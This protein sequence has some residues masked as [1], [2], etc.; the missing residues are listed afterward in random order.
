MKRP[1][2]RTQRM[3]APKPA[4]VDTLRSYM[5]ATSENHNEEWSAELM[6]QAPYWEYLLGLHLRM[7]ELDHLEEAVQELL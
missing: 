4:S 6:S 1:R 2:H 7:I 5:K 3:Q